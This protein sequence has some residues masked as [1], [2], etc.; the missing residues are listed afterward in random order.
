MRRNICARSDKLGNRNSKNTFKMSLPNQWN[1][2]LGNA[3]CLLKVPC[4]WGYTFV[5]SHI[6]K[7]LSRNL[8]HILA[9]TNHKVGKEALLD[10]S[11]YCFWQTGDRK[12]LEI[13]TPSQGLFRYSCTQ[14]KYTIYY[15]W[16]QTAGKSSG[17]Y[18]H[19][20]R[21]PLSG[22]YVTTKTNSF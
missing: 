21:W 18:V 11:R 10:W 9:W 7:Y 13:T 5:I 8:I 4:A 3:C 2:E 16:M 12:H 14:S 22:C 15:L 19:H 17:Y 20:N 6:H 1:Y